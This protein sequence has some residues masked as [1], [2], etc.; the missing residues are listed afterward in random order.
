[1]S[2]V[3]IEPVTAVAAD[4]N[5]FSVHLTDPI[6]A[7]DEYAEGKRYEGYKVNGKKEGEGRFYLDSKLCFDG[8]WKDDLME[9]PGKLYY[10]SGVLAYDGNFHKDRFHGFGKLYNEAP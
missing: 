6:Y 3:A 2:P 8:H 9:G 4:V 7:I 1:M 5:N 10:Q